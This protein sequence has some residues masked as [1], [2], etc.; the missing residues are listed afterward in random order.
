[1]ILGS[2]VDIVEVDRIKKAIDR[3]GDVFLAHLFTECE[4]TYAQKYRNSA[5]HFAGR[6]AVKEAILKAFG[7]NSH[8]RWKDINI[9]NDE[10]G[11]PI[12]HYENEN[13]QN[14]ILVS[15]SHTSK[16]A[17]ATAIITS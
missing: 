9:T 15:I 12:C 10:D 3:W 17:V 6:F 8:I 4:I 5:Q 11:K 16:Y 2:G 7:K 1:M 13:F 14:K